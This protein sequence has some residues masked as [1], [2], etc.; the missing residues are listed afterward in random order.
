IVNE[1]A[2]LLLDEPLAALDLQLREK[3][4][5]ELS[6]LQT[7]LQTTFV[8]VTHDQN[9]ALAVADY[10]AILGPNGAIEQVGTPQAIYEYP[11]TSFVAQFVGSTNL[12][13][14]ILLATSEAAEG[15]WEFMAEQLGT[16]SVHSH[17]SELWMKDGSDL[18]LSIRPEKLQISK[19]SPAGFDNVVLGTVTAIVYQG[20]ATVYHVRLASGQLVQIFEQN[21][22]HA[23]TTPAMIDYDDQ[24]YVY[25]ANH[26][27]TLL[28]R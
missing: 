24:V 22:H 16:F 25:W 15:C 11:A 1:P 26:A 9:E 14:G 10:M 20:R 8:Y 17:Q 7:Q 13:K 3:M 27:A 23:L 18:L 4:L 12:L 28:P 2:V 19:V 5:V 21:H 6:E